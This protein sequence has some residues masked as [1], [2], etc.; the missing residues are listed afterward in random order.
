M[1]LVVQAWLF[2]VSRYAY[3]FTLYGFMLHCFT[4]ML[5]VHNFVNTENGVDSGYIQSNTCGRMR[6]PFLLSGDDTVALFYGQK[7]I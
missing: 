5:Y 7:I 2:Y 4:F 6:D 3:C 1:T